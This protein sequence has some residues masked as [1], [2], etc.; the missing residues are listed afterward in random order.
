LLLPLL[1]LLLA[2]KAGVVVPDN[3]HIDVTRDARADGGPDYCSQEIH[4][5]TRHCPDESGDDNDDW[6]ADR[7]AGDV[8]VAS[9]H[10]ESKWR[11]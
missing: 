9:C 4:C 8:V 2:L 3:N 1:L 7:R 11:V 5:A 10:P 6:R